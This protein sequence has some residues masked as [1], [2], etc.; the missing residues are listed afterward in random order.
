MTLV[1]AIDLAHPDFSRHFLPST[2]ASLDGLGAVFSQIQE[3]ETIARPTA[4]ANKSLTCSEKNYPSHRL[5][6]L[7]LK[8]SI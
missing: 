1:D 2:D 8:W 5:K 4:F 6:F 7:A 3:G